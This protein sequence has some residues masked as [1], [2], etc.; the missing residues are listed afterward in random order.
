MT[1]PKPAYF[2]NEDQYPKYDN[3]DAIEVSRVTNI[4][5]DYYGVM[6]VPITFLN[7]YNPK[8][9]EIIG[10]G[11][12]GLA[13]KEFSMSQAFV[14]DYYRDGG[15]GSYAAGNP[16]LCMYDKNGKAVIPYMRV[17][18]R[19]RPGTKS[20]QNITTTIERKAKT[21]NEATNNN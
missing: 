16:L 8:Q 3:Y 21:T 20:G 9:F 17:L 1:K 10:Q 2:G 18:I 19:K 14:N 6:G 7:S 13:D 12:S 4:P 11:R 5:C 15:K